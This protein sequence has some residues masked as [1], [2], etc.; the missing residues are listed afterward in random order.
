MPYTDKNAHTK[1]QEVQS[2]IIL[3]VKESIHKG[4]Y[5]HVV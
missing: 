3:Y 5:V 1:G 4:I 2:Y